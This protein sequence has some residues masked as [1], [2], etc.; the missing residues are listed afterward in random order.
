MNI[1]GWFVFNSIKA[2]I[3]DLD[4]LLIDSELTYRQAWQQA[5]NTMGYEISDEYFQRLAGADACTIED[6]LQQHLNT[7][8]DRSL[9]RHLSA[10][11]WHDQVNQTGIPVMSGV[12]AVLCQLQRLGWSMAVA[13]NSQHNQANK[14]LVLAGL[15][16]R[17]KHLFTS[18]QVSKPKPSPDVYLLAAESLAMEPH[19]C[20]VL[21]DSY[22]GVQAALAAGM[23]CCWIPASFT[24][25]SLNTSENV[26]VLNSLNDVATRL[27]QLSV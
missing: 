8:F 1:S 15:D 7:D 3:F 17:F 22:T 13:T 24:D 25:T 16:H 4:G 21:E 18:D 6:T 26:L 12:D 11:S 2:L 9:F 10:E 5:L 27:Q 19:Q 14:L 23:K 20:M